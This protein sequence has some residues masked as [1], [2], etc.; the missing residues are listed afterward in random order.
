MIKSHVSFL[1]I[2]LN[3]Q[4]RCAVILLQIVMMSP[5]LIL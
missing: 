1:K 4:A 3:V 2:F 5:G